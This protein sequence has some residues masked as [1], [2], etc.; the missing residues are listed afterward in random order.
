FNL[1]Y[2]PQASQ[3]VASGAWSR[4][5]V[6]GAGAG[7][8]T[9]VRP[10]LLIGAELRHLRQYAS[11]GPH[12]L[13][14]YATFLGPTLFARISDHWRLTAAWSVQIAGHTAGEDH[15]LDLANFT[16]HEARLRIGYEFLRACVRGRQ[17]FSPMRRDCRGAAGSA[18]ITGALF[19]FACLCARNRRWLKS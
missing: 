13:A 14:G 9:Q 4:E 3:A 15:A 16:R 12:D 19:S 5:A 10:G 2:E 17:R 11:L 1:L 18:G 7:V 8:M 6:L